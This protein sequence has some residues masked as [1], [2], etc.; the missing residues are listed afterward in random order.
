M[1]ISYNEMYL[2]LCLVASALLLV[3]LHTDYAT[4]GLFLHHPTG[5]REL[6]AE[7]LARAGIRCDIPHL[8]LRL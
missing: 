4:R 3:A 8:Q 2:L 1:D 7:R 6:S 5:L